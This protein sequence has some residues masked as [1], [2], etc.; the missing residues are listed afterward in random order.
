MHF[1]L[2]KTNS[3]KDVGWVHFVGPSSPVYKVCVICVYVL[4]REG[5]FMYFP[6][7]VCVQRSVYLGQFCH[8]AT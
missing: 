8:S 4:S 7:R 5:V 1:G 2:N 6:E 3:L